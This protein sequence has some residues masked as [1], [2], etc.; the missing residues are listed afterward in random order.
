[1]KRSFALLGILGVTATAHAQ[2]NVTLYGLIDTSLVYTNNQKGGTNYQMSSGVE[3]GSRWGMKGAEDLGGGL[4][5]IFQ[6][7][8]GFSST[9]GTL[10]QNGRMFGRAAFVGI[11]S[12]TFGSFTAGRQNEPSADFVGPLVASNQWAGGIGA[13]P[14]DTDNLY[15]NS[16]MSNSI[17]YLSQD[18]GGFRVGGLFSLGGTAGNFSN[19]RIW[20]VAAG[21]NRGPLALGASY[22][23]TAQPNTALWD[24]TAGAAAISPNNTPIYSGYASARTLSVASVAANYT[25]GPAKFGLAYSNTNFSDLGSAAASAPIAKY[26]GATVVFD[27]YEANFNYQVTPALLLGV[28]YDYTHTRGA[29]NAH[30]DQGNIGGDYFLSKRTDVY[31]TVAYQKAS[32]VDST[33]KQAVAALW[34]VTASSNSHQI[35]GA[36]GLRHRF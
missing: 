30:Y 3:S 13:H 8:N 22:I 31:L 23:K 5:A 26:K 36:L 9:V 15:V 29:G 17:K 27:N 25:L 1:M 28:A 4:K 7:E 33:G 20:S 16:R 6:L 19:N 35:V 12:Q 32:G 14:G 2:S 34:P 21:Y 18:F 10:G 11:T 24:G